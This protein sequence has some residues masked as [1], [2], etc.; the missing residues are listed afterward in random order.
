MVQHIFEFQWTALGKIGGHGDHVPRHV[1]QAL[2][3]VQDQKMDHITVEVNA[4]DLQPPQQY[5]IQNP[6]QVTKDKNRT[7]KLQSLAIGSLLVP[8][9]R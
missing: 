4:Q 2:R 9:A 1:V 5:A 8:C 7:M 6:V 3:L